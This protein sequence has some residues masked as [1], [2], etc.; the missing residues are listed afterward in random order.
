MTDRPAS[1]AARAFALAGGVVF[2]GS[3]LYFVGCWLWQFAAPTTSSDTLTSA[4]VDIA[5]FTVFALHHSF[6]ART[7]FKGW[8][9]RVAPPALERSIYVWIASVLFIVTCALWQPVPGIA[10]NVT[11]PA[12]RAVMVLLQLAGMVVAVLGARR[13]DVWDLSGI[14]QVWSSAPANR[15]VMLKSGLYGWVRHPIYFAWIIVVWMPPTMTGTRLL[16]AAV[17]TLYLALAVPFEERDLVRTFGESYD[18]YRRAVRWRM[19]PGIY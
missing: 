7:G 3:L 19:L 4:V 5:V 8:I 1:P 15:R 14:R 17:S 13:L 16:F 6:F 18:A 10:W 12:G 2:V 9:G 11:S